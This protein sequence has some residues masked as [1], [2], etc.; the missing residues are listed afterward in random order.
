MD[1][2]GGDDIRVHWSSLVSEPA[3]DENGAE[4]DHCQ[5][6]YEGTNDLACLIDLHREQR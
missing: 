4:D 6:Y 3:V 2:G 1:E 5:H